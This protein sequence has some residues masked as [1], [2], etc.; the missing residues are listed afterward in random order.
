MPSG[1]DC[2][3]GFISK[4][5]IRSVRKSAWSAMPE[6]VEKTCCRLRLRLHDGGGDQ[7][8]Q[9]AN[10]VLPL[11][12]SPDHIDVGAVVAQRADHASRPPQISL[13]RERSTFS[14]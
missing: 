12:R 7:E 6:A 4:K 5:A 9:I 13:R 11:H 1:F 14:S 8:E 10:V 3:V 2:T